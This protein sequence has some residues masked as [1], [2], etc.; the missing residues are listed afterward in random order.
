MPKNALAQHIGDY[1]ELCDIWAKLKAEILKLRDSGMID[2]SKFT[3]INE[4]V[5]SGE[6]GFI[7]TLRENQ[8]KKAGNNIT[9]WL[10]SQQSKIKIS[11]FFDISAEAKYFEEVSAK[12]ES[13]GN[14]SFTLN[15]YVSNLNKII[16]ESVKKVEM[17]NP[18]ISDLV[19]EFSKFKST[20]EKDGILKDKEEVEYHIKKMDDFISA[21]SQ[22]LN[23]MN[24]EQ[25]LENKSM[26]LYCTILHISSFQGT[27]NTVKPK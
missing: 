5:E 3:Y 23:T 11:N 14:N 20:W 18:A 13:Q 9:K 6:E 15:F 17:E 2:Y 16:Q 7:P 12:Y 1:I 10:S 8:L 22:Y 25:V 24:I 21:Y 19:F 27:T 26:M 4:F